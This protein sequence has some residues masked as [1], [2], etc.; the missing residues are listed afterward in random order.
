MSSAY[1][2]PSGE[3]FTHRQ[4]LVIF[5]GLM[6]GLFLA[7]LDQTIVATALPT[8][9]GELGGLDYYA[10]VVTAY[11]LSSTVCTP[12]YGKVSDIYGRRITF[13]TAILIFLLGSLLA[14][15]ARGMLELVLARGVQGVGAGGVMALTF[16]VVGDIVSPRQRG[17]YIGFLAGT[18][19][20]ASVIGPLLGG[21]IVD[22]TTWR[23]VFLINLPV[24][25]AALVVISMALRLPV[26]QHR[27]PI[28]VTGALLLTI[29]VSLSLLALVW[30]GTEYAW[31]STTIVGLATTGLIVTAAF[32]WWE[33]RA[34]E[35]LLPIRLFRNRIFSMSSA[36]GFLVS[37]ALF[38][39][40]VF[41][42]L[43]LQVVNGVSATSSGLLILPLTAG[44]VT[45]SIGS[46]R[47]TTSTGRYKMFPVVGMAL[48]VVG[49]SLL[50]QMH[51]DTSRL[52]S[53]GYMVVLGLGVGMVLQVSLLALQNAVHYRDLGVATSSAQFF[54]SMGG[55][56]GVA[57]FGAIMNER[58]LTELPARLPAETLA[59]VS[60]E[61]TGLLNSPAAIRALPPPVGSAISASLELA[62]QSVFFWAIP[63]MAVGFACAC[64][65]PEIP[66][67]DTVGAAPPVQGIEETSLASTK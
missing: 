45:G 38:G 32:V 9:V 60:G 53:S 61:I 2:P 17:R 25:A 46:G 48:A 14:G 55:A 36:L 21:L 47:L 31:G 29:G 6:A 67:R 66:L 24:G 43:F 34:P 56:F 3:P 57:I 18:W 54:R 7:A 13:Q 33:T 15:V 20:V 16:A 40:V 64:Y 26:R 12:L 10:W 52:A 30:G 1:I 42:P 41:L 22:T 58:L 65:L 23:W 44:I 51:G 11:L 4:I 28:D 59:G 8:I 62:I 50:S 19:A 35:A 39:G 49:M 5:T 63:I 37:F 27:V